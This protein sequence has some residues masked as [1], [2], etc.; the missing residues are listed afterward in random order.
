[1]AGVPIGPRFSP[2]VPHTGSFPT[3]GRD[4]DA[5]FRGDTPRCLLALRRDSPHR[6]PRFFH[7]RGWRCL[8]RA[9]VEGGLWRVDHVKLNSLRG[10]VSTQFGREA[11][12][13]ID[14]GR[15]ARSKDPGS[16][17]DHAFVDGDRSEE[18]QQVKRRPEQFCPPFQRRF[19]LART[20]SRP[21]CRHRG[22]ADRL[23]RAE[24]GR[25]PNNPQLFP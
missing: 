14:T 10:L 9:A 11:Q 6:P 7:D 12:S 5:Q 18:R 1:M 19:P 8:G 2:N 21:V 15:N 4:D 24:Y 13:A 20:R 25:F 22:V 17:N 16:I 3:R 23:P